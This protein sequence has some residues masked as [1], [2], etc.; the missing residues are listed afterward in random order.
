MNKSNKITLL[1]FS[2]LIIGSMAFSLKDLPLT[3]RDAMGKID[4]IIRTPQ[5]DQAF[6]DAQMRSQDRRLRQGLRASSPSPVMNNNEV[7]PS[8]N[9]IKG[10]G[11]GLAY[12]L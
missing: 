2:L 4:P 6:D 7:D 5:I 9:G 1:T 12:G 3:R 11:L 8:M 10:S